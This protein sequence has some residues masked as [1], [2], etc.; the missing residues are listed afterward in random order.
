MGW[1]VLLFLQVLRIALQPVGSRH[2]GGFHNRSH[3]VLVKLLHS[4]N[5]KIQTPLNDKIFL[6]FTKYYLRAEF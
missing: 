2:Y 3:I 5:N 1:K 4:S 6:V